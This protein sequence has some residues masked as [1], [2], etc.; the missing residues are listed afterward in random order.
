MAHSLDHFRVAILCSDGFEQSEMTSPRDALKRTDALITLISP[1]ENDTVRGWTNGDWGEAFERTLKLDD[2]HPADFDAL[3]LPGG[4][5]NPDTLKG[6][7]KAVEF[8]RHF[9]E[10]NKPVA[11]ICHVPQLLIEAGVVPGRNLTSYHTVKTDL[12][13]A[14]ANWEDRSVVRHE[15]LVT[16]RNPDDLPDFNEAMLELFADHVVAA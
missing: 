4:V 3:L 10:N 1:G 8:V 11:A 5:L 6:E 14:G 15:N 13:N 16:S 9:F 12:L 2:A 7:R